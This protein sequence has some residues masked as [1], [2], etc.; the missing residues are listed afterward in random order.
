VVSESAL[1][2]TAARIDLHI[3]GS[4][5]TSGARAVCAFEIAG[6]QYLAVPQLARDVPGQAPAMNAGDSDIDAIVYFW[7]SGTFV[8]HQRL[9]VPGGEDAEFFCIGERAFLA[10]AS[11]RTG[12]GPYDLNAH[13]VV[14]EWLDGYFVPFQSFPTFGAKQWRHFSIGIRHF[15]ALAQGVVIPGATA[16]HPSQSTIYEWDGSHFVPFQTVPSAWGYNWIF[17]SIAGEA[18]LGYADHVEPS[19]LFR[20][21]GA[22][23][24]PFQE[25]EGKTGRAFCFFEADGAAYLAF[26]SLLGESWLYRYDGRV[27]VPHQTLCG[28]GAREFDLIQIA[29]ERYLIVVNFIHGTPHDPQ[30]AL[31]SRIYRWHAGRFEILKEFATLGATDVASFKADGRTYVVVSNSLDASVR[32]RTDTIVY[33][34]V[35]AVSNGQGSD[36]VALFETYTG[37]PDSIGANLA[38]MT[39]KAGANDPL[40]VVTGADMAIF[41]GDERDPVATSFRLSTRGFKELAGVSHL[42]PALASL[43]QIR[44]LEPDSGAWQHDARRLL[45]SVENARRSNSLE[46][47][48]D[49]IAVE[50]YRGR[51]EQIARMVDYCCAITARFLRKVLAD[52]SELTGEN[53]R[54]DYLEARPD[55]VHSLGATIP[56]NAVMIATFF[57]AGL[58]IAHR[59]TR[60]FLEQ[61][62]D[63]ARA[64]VLITGRQGR[65]TAGVTWTTNS[66][67]SM[68]LGASHDQLPLERMYIAPHAPSFTFSESRDPETL[69]G[70]EPALRRVWF[71]TRATVDLAPLMFAGYPRYAPSALQPPII[72]SSTIEIGEMPQVRSIDDMFAMTTRLRIVMEDPRQLLSGAVT[73]VAVAQLRV[74]RH[75]PSKVVVP[76]LSGYDYPTGL[77]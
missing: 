58:D 32:F 35:E 26:A 5:Q 10:T 51:E 69:R 46:L 54:L 23:F 60:W 66:V 71:S 36:L 19:R 56:I 43:I 42:G 25:L 49:V 34:I 57:L 18:M 61:G 21:N 4:L 64:M 76:G 74:N 67:C 63:W 11:I 9:P 41:F 75:D 31:D 59:T 14:Y 45:T 55:R 44:D 47:W 40:I 30:T 16:V 15:L 22:T 72:D 53:L 29:G 20:W 48:R 62:I 3:S 8:E 6:R 12:H 33:T 52:E 13:S 39:I 37:H 65:P 28:P 17:F 7:N 70:L 1:A 38:Q 27:F 68:I 77:L 73:D 24:E 50:A 2:A